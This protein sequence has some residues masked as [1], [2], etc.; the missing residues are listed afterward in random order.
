MDQFDITR[1]N[2]ERALNRRDAAI[3]IEYGEE[4]ESYEPDPM[5]EYKQWLEEKVMGG[6]K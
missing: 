4:Q 3:E 5:V 6:E 1:M 2:N